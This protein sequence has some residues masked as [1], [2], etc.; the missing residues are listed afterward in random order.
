VE[1]LSDSDDETDVGDESEPEPD[2]EIDETQV[3]L[4]GKLCYEPEPDVPITNEYAVYKTP[5][6][7]LQHRQYQ[8]HL[9]K[10]HIEIKARAQTPTK[11]AYQK[12][13]RTWP[14]R[15]LTSYAVVTLRDSFIRLLNPKMLEEAGYISN[16]TKGIAV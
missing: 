7:Q 3:L 1:F 2:T 9:A 10:L 12:L 4:D 8:D 5:I 16:E 13:Y 14:P 11:P 6:E 15:P